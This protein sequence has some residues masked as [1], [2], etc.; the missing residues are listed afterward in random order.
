[1][2]RVILGVSKTSIS[3]LLSNYTLTT[4]IVIINFFTAL[5]ALT[6]IIIFNIFL[7]SSNKHLEAHYDL[8]NFQLNEITSFLSKNAVK[9]I[10][11]FDDSCNRASVGTNRESARLDCREDSLKIQKFQNQLPQLDPT[12][13]QKYIYSNFLKTTFN[14]KVFDDNWIKFVDTED[15]YYAQDEVIILEIDDEANNKKI[16]KIFFYQKYKNNYFKF[17]NFLKQYFDKRQ[18]KKLKND[19]LTIMETIKT[20]K[21]ISYIYKDKNQKFMS[22]S[23]SPILKN[24]KVYGVVLIISPLIRIDNEGASQSILLT[25][26]FL[27]FISIMFIFSTLFSKSIVTPIKLLSKITQLERDKTSFKMEDKIYPN[28]KDEIGILSNDIKDMSQNLKQR[29]K[30]IEQFAEDVSHELKNPLAG[31]KSSSNLLLSK[32]IDE[33]NRKL[34]ISNISEDIDRMNFLISDISHYTL[35]QV[36]ISRETIEEIEL[37]KFFKDFKDTIYN[38]NLEILIKS[39]ENKI[40][41]KINKNKFLQVLIN[42]IDNASTYAPLNS[43]F[44]IFLK[45]E[46]NSCIINFVDQGSGISLNY[47][48]KIFDRFYTDRGFNRKSHSGLGL[49]ISKRIIESISGDIYLTKSSHL[50]FDGACFEI[51]LPLKGL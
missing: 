42:L 41:V 3:F 35:T 33:E 18:L 8:V 51:K 4:Q 49:S 14:V 48:D 22:R 37:V 43:K 5:L 45:I 13:A 36:E 19:N 26:F 38:G 10:M 20:K 25:N 11:T 9:R 47:K 34:L 40:K 46:D 24:N 6:F 27:F 21:S 32:N 12:Y 7:L 50:G 31:L 17:F 23:T 1:M 15:F 28:R 29:I 2:D 30:E 39:S 44:L 16:K